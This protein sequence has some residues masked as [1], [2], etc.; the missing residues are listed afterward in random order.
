[1]PPQHKENVQHVKTGASHSCVFDTLNCYCWG[2]DKFN[3]L[4]NVKYITDIARVKNL[5]YHMEVGGFYSCLI[6]YNQDKEVAFLECSGD[7]E[8]GQ[9]DLVMLKQ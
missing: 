4:I 2:D 8:N 3:Q 5:N 1:M 9:V 6:L 7:N